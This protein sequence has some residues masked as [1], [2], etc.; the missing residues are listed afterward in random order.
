MSENDPLTVVC[1]LFGGPVLIIVDRKGK[2]WQFED[3]KVCGPI[4][5]GKNGDP[6]AEPPE[7][8]PFWDAV[9]RWY[10]QG[11]RTKQCDRTHT[12]CVW[13]GPGRWPAKQYAA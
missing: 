6:I 9:Q 11:K 1:M 13:D 10:D 8:S 7:S 5:V 4:A 12:M 2:M 3:H